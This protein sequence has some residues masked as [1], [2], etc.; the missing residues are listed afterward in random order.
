M[1]I[2]ELEN[3]YYTFIKELK[4]GEVIKG[5]IISVGEKEVIVD[6]GY[7][8]EGIILR[9]EFKGVDIENLKEVEVY[10]DEVE[11][12]EGKIVLSYKKAI[13]VKGWQ[14][15]LS[16]YREGDLVKGTISRRVKGGYMVNVFG[17]E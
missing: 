16:E 3:A 7:K 9:E 10:V 4:E 6:V 5:K 1:E 15:L 17:V 13:E 14:K 2:S 12:E 8:S 11:D